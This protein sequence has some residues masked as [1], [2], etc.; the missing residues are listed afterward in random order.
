MLKKPRSNK[1]LPFLKQPTGYVIDFETAGLYGEPLCLVAYK[2]P[3]SAFDTHPDSDKYK[4]YT[5]KTA[6]ERF[7]K[8]LGDTPVWAHNASYEYEIVSKYFGS[9]ASSINWECSRT[10]AY[11]QNHA[12]RGQYS[13]LK[14]L[15]TT[16]GLTNNKINYSGEW[17]LNDELIKYCVQDVKATVELIK[18][19][20]K[21]FVFAAAC[22][23]KGVPKQKRR[24]RIEK[25]YHK[26]WESYRNLWCFVLKVLLPMRR[27]GMVMSL[28]A[29]QEFERMIESLELQTPT[30]CLP[31]ITKGEILV[32]QYKKP[33]RNKNNI[34]T[35]GCETVYSHCPVTIGKPI[36]ATNAANVLWV[37]KL[38]PNLINDKGNIDYSLATGV[39]PD[40][41]QALRAAY[42]ANTYKRYIKNY[43]K[44]GNAEEY[45]NYLTIRSNFDP[46]G[47]RTGRLSSSEPNIQNIG[48]S[49]VADFNETVRT[50][51]QNFRKIVVSRPGYTLIG[52]DIDRA[53]LV[54][55]AKILLKFGD[56]KLA[57]C[58][59]AGADPHQMNAEA[60][61]VQRVIAKTILFS[62]IYGATAHR[63]A[64]VCKVSL[65]EAEDL[66]ANVRKGTP[67]LAKAVDYYTGF[68][69]K[70]GGVYDLY[71][72]FKRYENLNS[73]IP[74]VAAR[75]QRRVFNSVIQG[76]NASLI[77]HETPKIQ[78]ILNSY[79][80]FIVNIVH[81]EVLAEVP[82]E[83]A[84][85][86]VK[87]L[88]D[89]YV[90]RLDL[91]P[92]EG[93]KF[94]MQWNIG[95]SWKEL[96]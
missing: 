4:V 86:A 46:C 49:R 65:D 80:G 20:H 16:L 31:V 26:S 68:A 61:G 89:L 44:L 33:Y 36:S 29:I 13:S 12:W 37:S 57:E 18:H 88:N 48:G 1:S 82:L 91:A 32:K 64:G 76:T 78:S 15:G 75:E 74:H 83:T 67:A 40:C 60:W 66:L 50:L 3:E 56:S 30:V 11:S 8:S 47:T 96:K 25:M 70:Y 55:L 77:V 73:S 62:V 38:A 22:R 5:T 43:K 90:N 41:I 7:F 72:D 42:V 52:A 81:D 59:N 94:S 84:E 28:D 14:N 79:G 71:G 51:Q 10:L 21:P 53:E 23:V 24:E 85:T 92:L 34:K 2:F 9:I 54:I 58:L 69:L 19:L 17:V 35:F 6:M 39:E 63:I 87:Q 45:P 95:S 27:V 93:V